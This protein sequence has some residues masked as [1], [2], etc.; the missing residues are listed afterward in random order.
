MPPRSQ[1][2]AILPAHIRRETERRLFKN[3][4][5]DYAGLAQLVRGEGYNISD[6]SLWRYGRSHQHE[7]SPRG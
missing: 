4:L 6:D 1:V 5:R 3:G 7:C 2:I